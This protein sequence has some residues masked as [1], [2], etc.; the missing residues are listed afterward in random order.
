MPPVM[1]TTLW[2][3]ALCQPSS[4]VGPPRH[5][6]MAAPPRKS[7][8]LQSAAEAAEVVPACSKLPGAILVVMLFCQGS[9]IPAEDQCLCRLELRS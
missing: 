8:E 6:G 2:A 7:I 5:F 9:G 1:L 4:D 3:W